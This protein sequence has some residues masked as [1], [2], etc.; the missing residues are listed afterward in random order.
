MINGT[1]EASNFL[2]NAAAEK[3]IVRVSGQKDSFDLRGQGFV[4][5]CHLQFHLKIGDCPQPSQ[6]NLCL[7]HSGVGDS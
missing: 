4:G 2:N 7:T 1:T 3:T 5:V 6:Q